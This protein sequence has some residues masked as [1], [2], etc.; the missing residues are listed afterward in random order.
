MIITKHSPIERNYRDYKNFDQTKFK[1]KFL[2]FKLLSRKVL[3]INGND[4]RNC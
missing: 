3:F 4:K 1:K 2:V